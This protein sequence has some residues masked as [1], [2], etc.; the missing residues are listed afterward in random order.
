MELLPLGPLDKLLQSSADFKTKA[1]MH[2]CIQVCVAMSALI[3]E[4]ILHRDLAARNVLV[5][6]I[7]PVHVKVRCTGGWKSSLLSC[8]S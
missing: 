5:Q 3:K 7:N 8:A 4:N 2:I 1:K 6:T